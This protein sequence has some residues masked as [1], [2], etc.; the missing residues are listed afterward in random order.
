MKQLKAEAR[1]LDTARADP[2]TASP[3]H[4]PA[5]PN[6]AEGSRAT[7]PSTETDAAKV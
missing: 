4:V 3:V 5:V 6:A 2:T 1:E 7:E